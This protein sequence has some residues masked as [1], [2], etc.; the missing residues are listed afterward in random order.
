MDAALLR[1]DERVNGRPDQP[2]SFSALKHCASVPLL[3]APCYRCGAPMDYVRAQ[4]PLGVFHG[5][6]NEE[7]GKA[8]RAPYGHSHSA[9][10]MCTRQIRR[11]AAGY[12]LHLTWT[13]GSE[14]PLHSVWCRA[15]FRCC[16]RTRCSWSPRRTSPKETKWDSRLSSLTVRAQ[17]GI[18]KQSAAASAFRCVSQAHDWRNRAK[19]GRIARF[20]LYCAGSNRKIIVCAKNEQD[21]DDW[22]QAIN[23]IL[24]HR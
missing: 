21:R 9:C 7:V 3:V 5:D 18:A 15:R 14:R 17:V 2:V 1:V 4:W 6:A 23:H 13:T 11:R 19:I 8:G 20:G 12:C 10:M 22:I 24:S 16:R